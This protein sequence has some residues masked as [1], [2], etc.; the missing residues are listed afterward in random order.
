MGKGSKPTVGFWYR[1]V[2]HHGITTGPID[3]F[4][5][6]RGGDKVA[7]KGELTASGTIN[8]NA[9][10][11]WGGE[12]DQGG[13]VGA[14]DVMFGEADQEVNPNLYHHFGPKACA[15]RGFTTVLF[16]GRYGAMNPYPQK[17]SYKFRQIKNGWDD[18]CWYPEKS[19]ITTSR[20]LDSR[21]VS[22][23]RYKVVPRSDAADYS[24]PSFD[25]S[26][27][28]LGQ[29]PFA[30]FHDMGSAYW[31]G[32]ASH[33]FYTS[34]GTNVPQ[35]TAVWMRGTLTLR[36]P[37]RSVTFRAW[38]DN[39]IQFFVNGVKVIDDYGVFGHYLE[40]V[41]PA[42]TFIDGANAVA[43]RGT[44]DDNTGAAGWFY[45]DFAVDSDNGVAGINP[46]HV[47]YY[48]RT[49]SE[50]G[51]ES[52]ASINEASLKAAADK[53][54][55]E[56]FGIC[57]KWDPASESV[58]DFEK[59]ICKLIGGS[60]N[61]SLEDGQWYLDLARGDYDIDDLP[62][63]T[64]DD[65]LDFKEQ[66]SILDNVVN[67]VSV[68]YFDPEKK[69]TI[70][71]APVRA[72]ALVA[73]F[74]TIHQTKEYPEIPTDALA[75][76][77]A[78][79]DM[80]TT[81]TPTRV[82]DLVTTRKPYAWR[83][84]Q[85]FRLQAPKRGIAD[86]VCIVGDLQTGTLKSGAIRMKAAQ[87]IYSMPATSFVDVEPGVDTRPAQTPTAIT[88]QRAI[89]APYIEVSRMLSRADL[90]AL[91]ADVGYVMAV[92][93]TAASDID[94]ELMVAPDGGDYV[95]VGTGHWCAT[96]TVVE[97]A[98]QVDTAFTM[99]VGDGLD[100]VGVGMAALWDDEIVRVDVID[101]DEGTITL[102]RG[103]ADTVPSPHAAG[104]RLWF[105]PSNFAYDTTEYTAG[106][107]INVKLLSNTGSQQQPLDSASA[108][109]I[110]FEQR[111]ARPY[112]PGNLLIN[113]YAYPGTIDGDLTIA[114]SHRD[115][116]LQADQLVD[117]TQGDIGPEAGAT[118]TLRIYN[119]DDALAR[120]VTGL[121]GNAY[122]YDQDTEAEDSGGVGGDPHFDK[123]VSLLH[124]DETAGATSF[125]DATGHGSWGRSG[126]AVTSAAMSKFGGCS[127]YTSASN[128]SRAWSPSSADFT[129]GTGDFTF[130]G[131]LAPVSA[132]IGLDYG[133][134]LQ[135]GATNA[136]GTLVL[137]RQGTV[138]PCRLMVQVYS[139]GYK[140]VF[141]PLPADTIPNDQF[142][143]IELS[144]QAGVWRLFYGGHKVA[145]A[146]Y[147]GAGNNLVG[148]YW[149]LGAGA[150][151][152]NYMRAYF[153]EWR[154]TK[155]VARHA[156]DFMPPTRP[157]ILTAP[158]VRPNGRLRIE[159]ESVRDSLTSYQHHDVTILRP[160]YG[161][162]YGQFYGGKS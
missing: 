115:R 28:P 141:S 125:A 56:G 29:A 111:Q 150:L 54:Y 84:N 75:V 105:Y 31:D 77:V 132:G 131:W 3:A 11:L 146:T 86:M 136:T 20:F 112:A 79:R 5:E 137:T 121:T 22:A 135:F 152:E 48:S 49:N 126:G 39:G 143:H 89:E 161:F 124:F 72:L 8:V 127:L 88:L 51:R 2:Y 148:V 159:L 40:V 34:P 62:I 38:V 76:R 110:E 102:A 133:R 44:D 59:R 26:A 147:T 104:S 81:A 123:V 66:P 106:E 92:A 52:T 98:G 17:A 94:Y 63:L 90:A 156:N 35:A 103:C 138:D 80:L 129:L 85:Y 162:N 73:S 116:L 83:P 15:F 7:W 114:W 119:E 160:G 107:A 37:G 144:R 42:S 157:G 30:S 68:S 61:R 33:G 101:I 6:F 91:P 117:T 4:L 70:V 100:G 120:E 1:V 13:I 25:D 82:F 151:N 12:K 47:L 65:I 19:A 60:F 87:D 45:F 21:S 46:A 24:A 43:V 58:E 27:W 36:A 14:L 53:L 113:G 97:A 41:L 9:P 18:G 99:Q 78:Q 109:P 23:W 10:N 153:D 64:D 108:V 158:T 93:A 122:S 130:D 71:S 139:G 67:S 149:M 50:M 154:L 134:V 57:P 155:G 96:A 128:G 74:G 55:N 118:A 145:E 16:K 142:T 69:E 32:V 140:N 95:D